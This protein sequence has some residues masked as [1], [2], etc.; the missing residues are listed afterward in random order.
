MIYYK[1]KE[2]ILKKATGRMVGTQREFHYTR[3]LKRNPKCLKACSF[4][5]WWRKKKKIKITSLIGDNSTKIENIKILAPYQS[6]RRR[7][8]SVCF[9]TIWRGWCNTMIKRHC[10]SS[11]QMVRPV[12]HLV[13]M[14][15]GRAHQFPKNQPRA[16]E[17][18]V[19]D[20]RRPD[21]PN[22]GC[23]WAVY[24]VENVTA[25]M[26]WI[27]IGASQIVAVNHSFCC[28]CPQTAKQKTVQHDITNT[29][30]R[31]CDHFSLF[32]SFF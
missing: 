19:R 15:V 14:M 27:G 16:A 31:G 6:A 32:S 8:L 13:A 17:A 26:C 5:F 2:K 7:H 29:T 22:R 18:A 20:S 28:S 1:K 25:P 12:A 11:L 23:G 4:S 30:N 10:H 3:E 9:A 21:L 24:I